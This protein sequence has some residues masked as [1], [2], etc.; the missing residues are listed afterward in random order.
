[1][2]FFTLLTLVLTGYGQD[3]EPRLA[4]PGGPYRQDERTYPG[5]LDINSPKR[6]RFG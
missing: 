3:I 6:C 2:S 5:M 4:G 1:L